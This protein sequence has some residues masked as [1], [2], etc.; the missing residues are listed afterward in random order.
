MKNEE[1]VIKFNCQWI[2]SAP[3]ERTLLTGINSWR[4]KL[5][6]AR[7]IGVTEDG[8]G[9]GNISIRFQQNEFII[10]GS[11]TGKFEKLN[12]EH[13]ALVTGYN[14]GENSLRSTGPI[15][16][17]S[18]SLTHAMIYE[19]AKDVQAVMHV[20]HFKLWKQ[21]LSSLPATAPE[22]DY[23]TPEMA[24]EIARLFRDQELAENKIFAMAGHH[25]GIVC[26]GSSL[27]EAGELLF[28]CFANCSGVDG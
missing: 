5:F 9:Y 4:D 12:E 8:I 2:Q 6:A 7:L 3:L 26:F 23:G 24:R 14:V 19:S 21:L 16:A 11:G 20:H 22:I 15:I 25:G 1:G 10:S 17:S 27:D 28:R 13:Y 18:E